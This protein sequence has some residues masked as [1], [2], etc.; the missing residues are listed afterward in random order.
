MPKSRPKPTEEQA[1]A[2]AK[3]MYG[4]KDVKA[5]AAAGRSFKDLQ[6]A[7]EQLKKY[8]GPILFIHGGNE[9][10]HVK[11]RVAMVRKRLDRGEVKIVEGG[12]HITTLAKPEFASTIIEFLRTGK[13]N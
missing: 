11:N 10:D 9:S 12:D 1:S 13:V 5:F 4:G 7:E 2:I 3:F 6:V 8:Q